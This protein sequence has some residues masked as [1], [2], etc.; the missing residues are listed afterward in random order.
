[1][2]LAD[3]INYLIKRYR[4]TA[5]AAVPYSFLASLLF[6]FSCQQTPPKQVER[7]FYYWKSVYKLNEVE[8]QTLQQ[9][10][11]KKLYI[12]FFDVDWNSNT[13]QP[14]P[15]AIIRFSAKPI[16]SI[17]PV[18]FIT[19]RTLLNCPID[20][21]GRLAENITEQ[22]FKISKNNNLLFNELQFDCDWTVSTRRKYFGFLTS[23]QN[24]LLKKEKPISISCTIRLHQIKYPQLTGVPP[25]GRGM[26]MFYNVGDWRNPDTQNSIFDLDEAQKYTQSLAEYPLPLDVVLPLFRWTIVYRN[27]RFRAF[28]NHVDEQTLAK[29]T[30]LTREKDTNNRFVVGDDTTAWGFALRRDDLLRAEDVPFTQLQ[31]GKSHLF[32]KIRNEK[33]T[34]ALYHLDQPT[35]VRYPNESLSELFQATVK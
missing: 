34:F 3:W 29:Q 21:I 15:K 19:N 16:V 8:Q 35:L 31:A 6:I 28:I 2:R 30:F 14:V 4:I 23:V 17:I 11:I 33:L 25:A 1:M 22:V 13:R 5:T 10:Q 32:E 7:A 12:K 20:Q 9:C 24:L 27:G 26:L 18:I